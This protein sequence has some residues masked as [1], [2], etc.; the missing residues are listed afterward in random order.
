VLIGLALTSS[1]TFSQTLIMQTVEEG[2]RGRVMS[3]Y[4]A[5][6]IA[7]WRMAALPFGFL[8]ERWGAREAVAGGAV[9]LLLVLLPASRRRGG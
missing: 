1:A 4:M 8:A 9:V 5:C 2:F 6:T 7:A 3:L